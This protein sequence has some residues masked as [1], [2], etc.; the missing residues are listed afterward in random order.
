VKHFRSVARS[1]CQVAATF[2][3]GQGGLAA[4]WRYDVPAER[5]EAHADKMR[6]EI[7][8]KIAKDPI[9]AGAHLLVADT[10]AS[11]VD[12]AERQLRDEPNRIPRWILVVESWGDEGPY[13]DLC[14]SALSDASLRS[15]GAQGPIDFGLYRLQ[16]TAVPA[17]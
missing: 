9:I 7:L 14:R 5:A 17:D 4:T 2:G 13:L 11:A 1:I 15:H 8:P 3:V 6:S 12:T 16:A 10:D